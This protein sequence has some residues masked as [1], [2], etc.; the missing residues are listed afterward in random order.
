MKGGTREMFSKRE[1]E[2]ERREKEGA[3]REE[4]EERRSELARARRIEV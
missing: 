1:R 3:V 2:E 4:G